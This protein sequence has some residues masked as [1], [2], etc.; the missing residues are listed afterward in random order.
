[1]IKPL[2]AEAPQSPPPVDSLT[3]VLNHSERVED[4][5]V[6]CADDLSS[7]NSGLKHELQGT[8]VSQGVEN[9]LVK[10]EA[11]ENKVQDASE[12]LTLVNA[13]LKEEIIER[14]I[15]GTQLVAMT[16]QAEEARHASLHDPLTGLPNRA[17]FN[18]RL[19][20]GLAVANRNGLHF[21]VMFLDLDDFKAINDMHGHDVGDIVLQTIAG[22]LKET[23]RDDD[24]VCRHG[25][26]EFLYILVNTASEH[27]IAIV[28]KKIIH[29]VQAPCDLQVRGESLT[30]CIKPSIGISVFPKDGTTSDVLLD[31]ADKAMYRAKHD[32]SGFAFAGAE[33]SP[34]L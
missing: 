20:H 28:A 31:L 17:L 23:T 8:E 34:P 13:A 18:D 22:R 32:K 2:P 6:E 24:T 27:D 30:L 14:H 12:E 33:P 3:Q 19:A 11:V 1:M 9:A 16:K 15:L 25:G 26:D 10:N 21:A 4:I 29:A 5:V 7:V